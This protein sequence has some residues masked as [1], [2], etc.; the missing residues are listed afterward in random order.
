MDILDSEVVKGMN[1]NYVGRRIICVEMNDPYNPVPS[2]TL[3]TVRVVDSCGTIHVSW[4]NGSTLGLVPDEDKYRFV[5][6][7][8]KECSDPE[9]WGC[10][11]FLFDKCEGCP[12]FL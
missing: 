10:S 3:G 6:E 4:D 5:D 9:F 8:T 7:K 12:K 1:H 11:L 2:G